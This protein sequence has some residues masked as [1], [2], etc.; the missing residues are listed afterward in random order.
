[1]DA[2]VAWLQTTALSQ[3]IVSQLWVWPVAEAVHFIGLALVMGIVGLLDLRLMGFF[4][5]VPIA[6]YREMV[7]YALAGFA[8]NLLSGGVF[9]VGHPEQYAHN[10]S[11]WLK[12][13]SLALAGA[14]AAL[15]EM[16]AARQ[17]MT[18]APGQATSLA[19]KGFGAVSLLAWL[20]VLY[21]GR[22]LPFIG[23]AY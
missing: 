13:V 2:L 23:D 5:A 7:P 18:L 4:P 11:W 19:M 21:W 17:A 6:A 15:F 16:T 8:L 10:L 3:F 22:M 14:N 9:L 20:G 12:V 1:M